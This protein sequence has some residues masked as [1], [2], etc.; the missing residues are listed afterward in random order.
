METPVNSE[1]INKFLIEKITRLTM[2]YDELKEKYKQRKQACSYFVNNKEKEINERV[3]FFNKEIDR[4]SLKI[5]NMEESSR[6]E[7]DKLK[8]VIGQKNAE[9]RI[10]DEE[11]LNLSIQIR[12]EFAMNNVL[13]QREQSAFDPITEVD[14]S[15][16]GIGERINN[17]FGRQTTANIISVIPEADAVYAV[18]RSQIRTRIAPPIT[19]GKRKKRKKSKKVKKK[20]KKRISRRRKFLN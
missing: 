19:G 6:K 17:A 3:K 15:R 7:T 2:K 1:K 4:L 10:K 14:G 5:V 18:D 8:S 9:I 20:R 16:M 11:I 12:D 13:I